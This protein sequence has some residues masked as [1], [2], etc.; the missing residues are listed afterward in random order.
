MSDYPPFDN[1][2][3]ADFGYRQVGRGGKAGMVRASFR[4]WRRATT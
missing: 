1:P 2:G 3:Q 4:A